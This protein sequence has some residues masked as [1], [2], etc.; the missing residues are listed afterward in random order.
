MKTTAGSL[1]G[2]VVLGIAAYLGSRVPAEQPAPA[3]PTRIAMVNMVEVVKNYK[4]AQNLE[5]ELHR[6]QQGWENALKPIRAKLPTPWWSGPYGS[7]PL[8]TEKG[9]RDAEKARSDLSV[10]EEE[11]KKDLA[12]V[13]G[14]VYGQIYR[15]VEEAVNRFAASNGYAV[16]LFYNGATTPDEKYS[17]SNV[18][19]K[20][21]LPWVVVPLYVAPQVDITATIYNNL[22]SMYPPSAANTPMT[23]APGQNH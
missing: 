22:N 7:H 9:R 20:F 13:S 6:R 17:A 4:K 2:L 10:M 23:A 11:A 21:S 1:A 8:S 5:A 18:A 12:K 19:R 16:V 15:D 3:A 14:E